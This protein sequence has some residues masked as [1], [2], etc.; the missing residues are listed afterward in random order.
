MKVKLRDLV[1]SCQLTLPNGSTY[2]ALS[3]L[4]GTEKISARLSHTLTTLQRKIVGYVEDYNSVRQKSLSQYA[5]RQDDDPS[6]YTFLPKNNKDADEVAKCQEN[7]D[8]FNKEV[9]SLLAKEEEV[10]V[11]PIPLT[12]FEAEEERGVVFDG[13]ALQLIWWVISDEKQK[14]EPGH[15]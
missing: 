5:R 8:S 2:S 13:A 15:D 14:V 6:K 1:N 3:D 4:A 11:T 12:A 10:D 7:F 9:E